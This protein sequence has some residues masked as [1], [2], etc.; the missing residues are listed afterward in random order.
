MKFGTVTHIGPLQRTD[1]QNYEI[2]LIQDGGDRYI[3]NH[4]NRDMS[5]RFDRSLRNLVRWR[6]M[7]LLSAPTVKNL[8]F[9]HSRRLPY[10]CSRLADPINV[11]ADGNP[12]DLVE[13]FNY[14]AK[15]CAI[16]HEHTET[17]STTYTLSLYL[18][19]LS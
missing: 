1:R 7:G 15:D 10:L 16:V 4:K 3:E 12:V 5:Q 9:K 18:P 11:V 14:V 8:N 13:R 2:L 6:I 19:I 17:F